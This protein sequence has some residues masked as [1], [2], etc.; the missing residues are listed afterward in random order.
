MFPQCSSLSKWW[1]TESKASPVIC[2]P[3][4]SSNQHNL[5]EDTAR[6]W[7]AEPNSWCWTDGCGRRRCDCVS[8][9]ECAVMGHNGGILSYKVHSR[10][11]KMLKQNKGWASKE[12]QFSCSSCFSGGFFRGK[13]SSWSQRCVSLLWTAQALGGFH[14]SISFDL[15]KWPEVWTACCDGGWVDG[16]TWRGCACVRARV[17]VYL[18]HT[19][20]KVA[21]EA[22]QLIAL[23]YTVKR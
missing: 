13:R 23:L 10:V 8:I 6:I 9:R 7:G 4:P 18:Q 5:W 20:P 19:K 22:L 3:P 17:C 15:L 2:T 21:S 1:R 16:S 14:T 12:R 11:D